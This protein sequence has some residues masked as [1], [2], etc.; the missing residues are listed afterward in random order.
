MQGARTLWH[1]WVD[2]CVPRAQRLNRTLRFSMREIQAPECLLRFLSLP[3]GKWS[4]KT[5][6][7]VDSDH[8]PHQPT[9]QALRQ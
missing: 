4:W 3:G 5:R 7:L 2:I 6:S 1:P 9:P 8:G